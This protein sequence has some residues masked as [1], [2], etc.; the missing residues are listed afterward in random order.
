MASASALPKPTPFKI[1]VS[2]D[3]LSFINQRVATARIPPGIELPDDEA[4][5]YG[6]PP[7]TIS[8][9]RDY[10][11]KKYDW[12][13]VEARI[14]AH[15]T[16]FTLPITEAGEDL[17]IHFV[18]HRS[19][20]P[21]AIPLLF[22]HG[23]PGSFLEVDKIIDSLT[24]P[25]PGQQAYH[26]VAPSLPGF[27]FSSEPKGPDFVLK[28]MATVDHKLMQA[29]GYTKY[30]A[31]GGD[32]GSLIVRFIAVQF[33]ESCIAVHVNMLAS[34]PPVWY[35]NPLSLAYLVWW[36]IWQD[37]SK[38][39]GMLGRMLWWQKE[40]GGYLEIQGTK[41]LTVSYGLVDS[42]I[43]MLA[44]LRD[45]MQHLTDDDWVW[46]EEEVITWTMLYLIPGTSG[47][48]Q[49]YKNSKGKKLE[50]LTEYLSKPISKDVD[51]GVSIFPKE[52]FN[53]P[54][55]WAACTVAN[56]IAFWKEHDKGGH[57]PSVEK[58]DVLVT[59]IREFTKVID[60]NR[61]AELV[62]SGK[63]KL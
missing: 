60:K 17:T 23:W 13:A 52:V 29:L 19:S 31:Q 12:R 28:D 43:G 3:L 26:V 27:V 30:M 15:L 6:A 33:P 59:D 37:K 41:P 58:P 47:A 54:R 57:F 38:V 49:I 39:G 21:D 53:V 51:F 11:E 35:K 5:S 25:E 18:H 34:G 62:K 40:E 32:W 20:H 14:N 22:Q 7:A 61:K 63:L 9:I 55:W 36:A 45:K 56:N 48:A 10:W 1:S 2:D 24:D 50:S 8:H 46:E 4:W 42:P 44:W 16:M